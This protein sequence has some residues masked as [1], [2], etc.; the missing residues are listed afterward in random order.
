MLIYLEKYKIFGQGRF[1]ED[2]VKETA[3]QM[4][5]LAQRVGNVPAGLQGCLV[6]V[7]HGTAPLMSVCS[8]HC[9]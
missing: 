5:L 7:H 2:R 9:L 3:Y 1:Q 4:L 6:S 8:F